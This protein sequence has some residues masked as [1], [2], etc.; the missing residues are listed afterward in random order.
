MSIDVQTLLSPPNILDCKR[1]LC[2]QPHPDDNE[3][4]MGGIIAVL[5]EAGCDVHYLTVTNGNRGNKDKQASREQ[6][7][8]VRREE[9]ILA[10]RHL[11][12]SVF[13]FMDLD[14]STLSDA[15]G[16]SEAIAGI[17][18]IVKPEA[19][20][21]PDPWLPYEG[22]LDHVI[23]GRAAASAFT[24]YG[25]GAIGYYFTAQPNTVIDISAVFEEKFAA[26]AFH[27]SQMTQELLA[28]Y[29]I[30]FT[31]KAQELATG[32]DF[33]LGEGLKVLSSLHSHCFVDAFKM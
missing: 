8:A 13:H 7:A 2:I 21:S 6:T 17:L 31:M 25:Q 1:I 16:L 33:A 14:D 15:W 19:I 32:K 30:Y 29:R 28:M 22:H 9:A 10:G 23:T 24:K 26:I 11:G 27:D 3:I 20:F 12:A 4:G 5:A 18:R